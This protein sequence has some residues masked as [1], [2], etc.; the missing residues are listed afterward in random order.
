MGYAARGI[1]LLLTSI[2]HHHY[3]IAD[4]VP[5]GFSLVVS[6]PQ[7]FHDYD[8]QAVRD[9]FAPDEPFTRGA[10]KWGLQGIIRLKDRPGD[11]VLFVTFGQSTGGHDFDEG[12]NG[13]GILRWQSQPGQTLKS[14]AIKEFIRQDADR[15]NV[16]LFLRTGDKKNGAPRPYT[17][18]GRLQHHSHDEEREKPVHIAWELIDWPIPPEVL[19]HMNLQIAEDE[20]PADANAPITARSGLIEITP[21]ATQQT[22]GESTRQFKARKIR[23]TSEAQTKAIGLAGELLALEYE[24]ASLMSAGRSDLAALVDHVSIS[25]GDG[26]GYDIRSFN[27]DGTDRFVEV[28]TTTGPANS[29]FLISANEVAFS[30]DAGEAFVLFRISSFDKTSNSGNFFTVAGPIRKRWTLKETEYQASFR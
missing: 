9:L 19:A 6:D 1:R 17:Y 23:R 29:P 7:L 26:A 18:L 28:K 22:R 24:K 20:P 16:H 4:I 27:P 5:K 30:E 25:Q 10:G 15:S 13:Q 11:F 12:I 2:R 8:R 3:V 21:P 14:G